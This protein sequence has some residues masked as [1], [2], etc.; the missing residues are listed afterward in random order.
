MSDLIFT[1]QQRNPYASR[2]LTSSVV[3]GTTSAFDSLTYLARE[4]QIGDLEQTIEEMT[5]Q[6]KLSESLSAEERDELFKTIVV[7][8]NDLNALRSRHIA[9]K[10]T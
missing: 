7:I 1:A 9:S 10:I 5:A 3:Q 8:Q 4:L 2:V 6:L